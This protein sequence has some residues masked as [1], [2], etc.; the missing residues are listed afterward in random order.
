M[1]A[2]TKI[3]NVQKTML[4]AV[5]IAISVL[6]TAQANH[7]PAC[8][9]ESANPQ[10]YHA[11]S[12][13]AE[14]LYVEERERGLNEGGPPHGYDVDPPTTPPPPGWGAHF[15]DGTWVYREANTLDGLQRGGVSAPPGCIPQDPLPCVVPF[16]DPVNDE[17]CGHPPDER[18]LG[19]WLDEAS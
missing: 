10:N 4:R 5:V 9:I 17:T 18:I 1:N 6:G 3:S 13:G 16:I 8:E 11:V 12:A 19:V 7:Q 2:E 14:I 15:G